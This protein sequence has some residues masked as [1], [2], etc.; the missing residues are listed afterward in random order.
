[1]KDFGCLFFSDKKTVV[2][3]VTSYQEFSK[4][5]TT[6]YKKQG[7]KSKKNYFIV[8]LVVNYYNFWHV[9]FEFFGA[10]FFEFDTLILFA[11]FPL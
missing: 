7:K 4:I 9:I 1:M 6:K 11:I 2:F 5:S 10:K 8:I 3:F